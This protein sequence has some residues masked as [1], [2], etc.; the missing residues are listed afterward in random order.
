MSDWAHLFRERA[1]DGDTET[2]RFRSL[3]RNRLEWLI[4]PAAPGVAERAL[5]LYPAQRRL[6]R[7]A[8]RALGLA[9]R[10]K[11]PF[12]AQTLQVS[13][14]TPFA[15]FLRSIAGTANEM[16][17]FALLTGNPSV[18][19]RRFT[20]LLFSSDGT[21][22]AV[23]KAGL[24]QEA[25]A[26]IR[27]ETAFVLEHSSVAGVPPLLGT[28]ESE[29]ISAFA[30]NYFDGEAPTAEPPCDLDVFLR[31]WVNFDETVR[32]ADLRVWRTLLA[33]IAD[34]PLLINFAGRLGGARVHPTV[35]HGDFAPW[36][37]RISPDGKWAVFDWETGDVRGIPGWDWVHYIVSSGILIRRLETDALLMQLDA[38]LKSDRFRA[39]AQETGI[40][41]FE[42][43]VLQ[44]YLLYRHRIQQ[45]VQGREQTASLLHAVIARSDSTAAG[46]R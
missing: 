11:V 43:E 22:V 20:L 3:R 15:I 26:L 13:L 42:N 23:V 28:L 40:S 2:L 12:K 34:S 10:L 21:P 45:P 14:A 19:G 7:V 37:I 32:V 29:Q 33:A 9:L 17:P 41:G 6:A 44:T 18:P 39:F 24:T 30:T 31:R 5:T 38:L 36:N 16:P 35:W 25:R 27:K 4:L 8:K 46:R 1:E